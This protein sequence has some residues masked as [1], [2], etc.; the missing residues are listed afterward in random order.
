MVQ[1]AAGL[2][3][4]YY[5]AWYYLPESYSPGNHWSIMR[6]AVEDATLPWEL[7]TGVDLGLRALPSGQLVLELFDHPG[8]LLRR[9]LAYPPP[10][11]NVGAWFFVEVHFRAATQALRP[12]SVWLDGREVYRTE[13]QSSAPPHALLFAVCSTVGAWSPP[14]PTLYVDDVVMSVRR[15][16]SAGRATR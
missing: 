12:L 5:S 8:E 4:A 13:E 2:E 9:P 7:A 16:T 11:V 14:P 10:I 1:P 3:D 15:T 6:F